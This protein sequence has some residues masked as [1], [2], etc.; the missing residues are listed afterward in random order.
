MLKPQRE[1][2][3]HTQQVRAANRRVDITRGA[4]SMRPHADRCDMGTNAV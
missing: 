2:S 1:A 4:G 3:N